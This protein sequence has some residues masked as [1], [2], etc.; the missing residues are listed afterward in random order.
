MNEP[1]APET[2]RDRVSHSEDESSRHLESEGRKV[3]LVVTRDSGTIL[4]SVNRVLL[5]PHAARLSAVSF[6]RKYLGAESFALAE[7]I[8]AIGEDLV[9][10]SRQRDTTTSTREHR[11]PGKDLR[12][13][14]GTWALTS[15]GQPLGALTDMDFDPVHWNVRELFFFDHRCLEV[16]SDRLHMSEDAIV[17]DVRGR[18]DASNSG[19][20]VG[21]IGRLFGRASVEQPAIILRRALRQR[22]LS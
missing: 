10:V 13:F 17:V 15:D 2:A 19:D 11:A 1:S 21:L 6:R 18:P 22:S 20:R 16:S 12:D 3:P 9:F 14:Q 4:G 8:E 5:D 7:D